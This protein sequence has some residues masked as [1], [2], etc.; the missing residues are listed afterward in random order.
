M[1]S[2]HEWLQPYFHQDSCKFPHNCRHLHLY[3]PASIIHGTPE[4]KL[5][6][7]LHCI[8]FLQR[9]APPTDTKYSSLA[10]YSK[11]PSLVHLIDSPPLH[12]LLHSTYGPNFSPDLSFLKSNSVLQSSGSTPK[13]TYSLS[14]RTLEKRKE[15]RQKGK[16]E[17][18]KS[19]SL[20][21][22]HP[23]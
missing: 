6:H 16:K 23:L 22:S 2:P 21:R 17:K 15:G 20:N 12:S 7:L 11:G 8:T 5:S 18:E 10:P 4:M 3:S 9:N 19:V 14:H 13:F 1:S